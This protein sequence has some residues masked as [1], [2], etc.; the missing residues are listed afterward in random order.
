L[1]EDTAAGSIQVPTAAVESL[2]RDGKYAELAFRL[3]DSRYDLKSYN[4]YVNN[5]PLFGAYGKTISGRTFRGKERIELTAGQNKIEIACLNE[6]GAESYRTL[7]Y[8]YYDED[9]VGNLY[10][11]G[12][13]VSRYRDPALNLKYAAK[14]AEDLAVLF[15]AMEGSAFEQVYTKLYLNESVT[16]QSIRSAKSFIENA[17][18]DDTLILFIAGHGIHERTNEATY[19][20]VTHNADLNN[21]PGSCADFESIESL[22]H[23]IRPRRKLFLMDT[24]E[25]GE[26]E[27]EPPQTQRTGNNQRSIRPRTIRGISIQNKKTGSAPRSFLLEKDRFIY[28]NLARRS[29]AVVFSSSGGG[30]F[31]YEWDEI[32]NGIFTE[33]I[34]N[35]FSRGRADLDGDGEITVHE[36]KDYVRRAVARETEGRQ[37]PT[38]DRDNIHQKFGFRIPYTSSW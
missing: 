18:T 2:R 28:N 5:V 16:P 21:I 30:E 26:L 27:E 23:N 3:E 14:D 9:T 10:F 15:Q 7:N 22:L 4:V 29:G 20:F 38:V 33:E 34:L 8:A 24:C 17:G 37:N 35:A 1:S 32:E 6:A 31:S 25:S 12:F 13:G 19:Y 36:L 11:V